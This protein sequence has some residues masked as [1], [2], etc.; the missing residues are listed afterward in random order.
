MSRLEWMDDALC[1]EIGTEVFFPEPNKN[2]AQAIAVCR[3]C[4]V[5]PECLDHAL[6]L[7]SR[8]PSKVTG[9]WGGTT[10][11]ERQAMRGAA[12]RQQAS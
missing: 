2:P 3:R 6:D 12:Y 11:R 7:D 4:P 5:Q 1:A 8:G 9:I 10:M